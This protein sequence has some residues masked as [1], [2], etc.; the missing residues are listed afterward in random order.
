MK[1]SDNIDLTTIKPMEKD[2]D[3]FFKNQYYDES[4][5]KEVKEFIKETSLT[6]L[7]FKV[8]IFEE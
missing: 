4:I 1:L 2:I 8:E 6:N 5:P 7:E 3:L